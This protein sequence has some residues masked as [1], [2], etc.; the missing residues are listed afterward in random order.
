MHERG[1]VIDRT[2]EGERAPA[3]AVR[4]A[5]AEVRQGTRPNGP[6]LPQS[7]PLVGR[8]EV[9]LVDEGYEF[10]EGPQWMQ[11]DGVLLFSDVS[12]DTIY[13]LEEGDEITVFRTPSDGANGSRRRSGRAADRSRVE[14]APGDAHTRA[15]AR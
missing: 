3:Q 1:A 2:F 8:G 14:R 13:Q 12:A 11:D 7:D 5:S 9:E 4:E 6:R 15:T 10:T